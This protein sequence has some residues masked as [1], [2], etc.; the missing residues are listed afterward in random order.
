MFFQSPPLIINV[1]SPFFPQPYS[2]ALLP[3]SSSFF[4]YSAVFSFL[5]GVNLVLGF[6]GYPITASLLEVLPRS[7]LSP[8]NIFSVPESGR[9]NFFRLGG[10]IWGPANTVLDHF[11]SQRPLDKGLSSEGYF[12]GENTL[13]TNV[14]LFLSLIPLSLSQ[15]PGCTVWL[16]VS[17]YP[18]M[19]ES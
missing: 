7:T 15:H 4:R 6:L 3:Y 9:P 16:L 11:S 14:L 12:S 10:S 2:T 8:P 1:P 17:L 13:E 18:K 19:L 5:T